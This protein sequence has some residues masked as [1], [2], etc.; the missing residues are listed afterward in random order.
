MNSL[1]ALVNTS[2]RYQKFMQQ[3]ILIFLV[4]LVVLSCKS[5]KQGEITLVS[6]KPLT[7]VAV[8]G[9]GEVWRAEE[10]ATSSWVDVSPNVVSIAGGL[11]VNRVIYA[12]SKFYAI[13]GTF[14]PAD[15]G[16]IMSSVDG[17]NWIN[18]ALALTSKRLRD[19]I[20]A[21]NRFVVIGDDNG[22]VRETHV[23]TDGSTWTT[24]TTPV[25]LNNSDYN[26]KGIAYGVD[27][28]VIGGGFSSNSESLWS[29]D[30]TSWNMASSGAA[31]TY[32]NDVAFG[33]NK[34]IAVSRYGVVFSSDQFA[35]TWGDATID[36]DNLNAITYG[37]GTFMIVGNAGS[38]WKSN[39]GSSWTDCS[40][41][42]NNLSDVIHD[43]SRFVA[44]GALGTVIWSYDGTAWNDASMVIA[45]DLRGIAAGLVD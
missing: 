44:V 8:G 17:I 37:N 19:I 30:G 4:L 42:A 33:Q 5:D 35:T 3:G 2:K 23:S 6:P 7:Y 28:F 18:S 36:V 13:G 29:T 16:F 31:S 43:G 20:Y 40:Y 21:N 11:A 24:Y 9:T 25:G 39:D 14:T 41:G 12:Q 34:F 22:Q 32:I 10:L 38:I 45:G 26:I 15:T 27:R 1:K